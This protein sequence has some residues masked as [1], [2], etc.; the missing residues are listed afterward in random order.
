MQEMYRKIT[1]DRP[2]NLILA[3]FNLDNLYF[4]PKSWTTFMFEN[5][6]KSFLTKR[7]IE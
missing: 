4:G 1:S 3:E 7:H 2:K 5:N 6:Q